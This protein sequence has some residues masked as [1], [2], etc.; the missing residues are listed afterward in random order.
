MQKC[1]NIIFLLFAFTAVI[2]FGCTEN[3]TVKGEI[4]N[5]ETS[6]VKGTWNEESFKKEFIESRKEEYEKIGIDLERILAEDII[7]DYGKVG[8]Y[9]KEVVY[10]GVKYI[11]YH[12]PVGEYKVINLSKKLSVVFIESNEMYKNSDGYMENEVVEK[13]DLKN[14]N[15]YKRI[16]ISEN[17]HITLSINS[18]VKLSST[19]FMIK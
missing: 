19:G 18:K 12:V 7:L 13:I 6:K 14:Y 3:I 11:E 10:D 1:L 2:L 4:E 17:V 9:G 16:K 15:D 5:N 8:E